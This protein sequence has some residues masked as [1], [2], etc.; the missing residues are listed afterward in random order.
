MTKKIKLLFL[1]AN[2]KDTAPLRLGE[3]IREIEEKLLLA[4]SARAFEL[5]SKW[6]VRPNDLVVALMRYRPTIVHFSGHG[7]QDGVVL[8]TD[9]GE[10]EPVTNRQL[11]D[12]F[13]VFK[14]TLRLVV[15]NACFSDPQLSEISKMIDYTIGT[16]SAIGDK[17]AIQFAACLYQSLAFGHSVEEA[18]ELAKCQILRPDDSNS[19]LFTLR[20]KEGVDVTESFVKQHS[21]KTGSSKTRKGH[22]GDRNEKQEIPVVP[23]N[24]RPPSP[25]TSP[26]VAS[27]RSVNVESGSEPTPLHPVQEVTTGSTPVEIRESLQ[28]FRADYPDP[29]KVAFLMMRFGKTQAHTNIVK[30]IKKALDPLGISIVRADDKQY[31]DDLFPNVL[32]YVYGCSFAISVFERI[33]TEEFN[34][35][36]ALEVGY[37]LALRK[38]VCL[39]KDRTLTTLHADLVGKL[40]RVF[41]PLDPIGTIPEELARWLKD[42][43]LHEPL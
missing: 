15:L 32:T 29:S 1:A 27:A 19:E 13:S 26:E 12:I 14:S 6:A 24:Q 20:V 38:Q 43:G 23:I 3:E 4:P 40:Y 17:G 9:K 39:L 5:I 8:E 25:P 30:G 7:Q 34:P 2:P 37:M 31:H 10:A 16:R 28:R 42:K 22:T 21:K 18:F 36:V 33:E 35:N 41:D 11:R